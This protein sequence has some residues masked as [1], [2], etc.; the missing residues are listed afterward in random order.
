MIKVRIYTKMLLLVKHN[1]QNFGTKNLRAF[2]TRRYFFFSSSCRRFSSWNFPFSPLAGLWLILED[3]T[4]SFNSWVRGFTLPPESLW[5]SKVSAEFKLDHFPRSAI[6][7]LKFGAD[8]VEKININLGRSELEPWC[9]WSLQ[10]S[11]KW[12]RRFLNPLRKKFIIPIFILKHIAYKLYFVPSSS[13]VY[14]RPQEF[15]QGDFGF[16][17]RGAERVCVCVEGKISL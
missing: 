4:P 12:K 11:L 8:W 6:L 14:G 5:E 3:W 13:W 17:R 16:S 1:H 9:S 2:G 7:T 10:L 15:F